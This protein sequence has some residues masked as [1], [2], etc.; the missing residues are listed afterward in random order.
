MHRHE[1]S[2]DLLIPVPDLL[3][4][5]DRILQPR[6]VDC[7]VRI[8]DVVGPANGNGSDALSY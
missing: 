2:V 7:N 3:L 6:P 1:C 5:K 4:P 8:V